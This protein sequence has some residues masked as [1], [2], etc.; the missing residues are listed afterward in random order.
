[1]AMAV[2]VVAMTS[3]AE[4]SGSFKSCANKKVTFQV[5]TGET[6]TKP[7][8]VVVKKISVKGT[9]CATAYEFFHLVYNGEKISKKTGYPLGYKCKAAEFKVPVGYYAQSCSKGSKTIQ[10]AAQGG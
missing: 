6:S 8:S 4:A 5:E 9:D 1:M 7:Y 10:Y 3:G 2:L